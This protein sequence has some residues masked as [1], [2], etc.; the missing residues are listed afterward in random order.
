M[1][2]STQT[3]SDSERHPKTTP[4]DAPVVTKGGRPLRV[5]VVGCGRVAIHHLRFISQIPGASV[6]ALADQNE[7]SARDLGEQYKVDQVHSSLESM[8]EKSTPDVLHILTPPAQHYS[9]ALLAIEHGVHVLI[10]K[11]VTFRAWETEDLYRRA[12]AKGLSICPDFIQLF[13]PT[14]LRARKIAESGELGRVVSV[15]SCLTQDLNMPELTEARGLHWSYQLPGGVLHNYITHPLYL[16]LHF[17]GIPRAIT[18]I[19]RSLGVLPQG[20]T[21]HLDV[22]IDTASGSGHIVLSHAMQCHPSYFLNVFCEKGVISVNFDTATLLVTRSAMMPRSIDRATSNFRQAAFLCSSGVR[23]IVDFVRGRLVPYQGLQELIPRFYESIVNRT[24][25]PI[26]PDFTMALVRAEEDILSQAGKLHLDLH[27]RTSHPRDYQHPERVVVTGASGYVGSAVVRRLVK[28]GYSVRALV[29]PLSH[30]ERLEELGVEILFG[31]IRDLEFTVRAFEGMDVVIH[32]AAG[33]RGSSNHILDSC[34]IGTQNVAEAARRA[35]VGRVIYLSSMSVYDF[36]KMKDGDVVTENSPLDDYP[37]LRGAYSCGKRK[38]EDVA[39]ARLQDTRPSWTILRP[40]AIVGHNGDLL[41]PIGSRVGRYV[42]CMS[43]P[44]KNL[45]LVHVEDVS[46]GLVRLMQ[47]DSTA[48]RVFVLSASE[49]LPIRDYLEILS[50][51]SPHQKLRVLHVPFWFAKAGVGALMVL[52]K[53]TGKGPSMN[54]RRLIYLY[55]DVT[56]NSGAVQEAL[57]WEPGGGLL[58]RLKRERSRPA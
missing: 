40:S 51:V 37:E 50:R 13:H 26:S 15:E 44:K 20:L 7:R 38:A 45:R 23:N 24:Q 11:P 14:L 31:D 53:I 55:R 5:A 52:R 18:V 9:Q 39:L 47:N 33:L 54:L 36:S 27:S 1:A 56:V 46:D 32:A 48:G 30:V 57:S 6:V 42:I 3:I 8:L 17:L 12:N 16:A 10:E 34:I 21:D 43:S 28:E 19:P 41:G 29:R 58:D 25:A 4:A 35:N 49:K 2:T 22:L